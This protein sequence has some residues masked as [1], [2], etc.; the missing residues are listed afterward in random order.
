VNRREFILLLGSAV[1]WPA[2]AHSQAPVST[3]GFLSSRSPDESQHL[4]A[5]FLKGLSNT[6]FV[7]S[8]NVVIEYRW[9]Q[10]RYDQ[11]PALAAELANRPVSVIFTA[12]GPP[13]ALAAKAATSKIPIVFSAANDP[14]RLGLVASLAR[15]GG[16]VTG[17]STLT[18][19]LAMKGLQFVTELV[20]KATVFAFLM[21]PSNPTA[22]LVTPE[23]REAEHQLGVKVE[24]L[25][26]ATES[27]LEAS[28]ATLKGLNAGGLVVYADPF[29]DSRRDMIVALSAR[30]AVP[31]IYAWRDYVASGG[32]MSYGSSLTGSYERAGTYVGRILGGE[33]PADLPVQQPAVFELVI[34]MKTAT[35]LG[36]M[37]PPL[38]LATADEV[39]E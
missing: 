14:V 16:N 26:A 31:A 35:T 6:G 23:A 12:G 2:K 11:L 38:L 37:V 17:M 33:K 5:A 27:E 36:L 13:S 24:L 7:E 25:S 34:N 4:V 32:L 1:A 28:F 19:G 18:T 10:G 29:F 8:K 21:N 20:P 3:V 30:Y 39:I 9:A 22:E 15:P